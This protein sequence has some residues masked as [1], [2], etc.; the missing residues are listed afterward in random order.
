MTDAMVMRDAGGT[1]YALDLRCTHAGCNVAWKA[2]EGEF[3]CPCH[4]GAFDKEGNVLKGPPVRPLERLPVRIEG[5]IV[6]VSN[7]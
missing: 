7:G 1:V 5:G 4:G 2:A 6:K 3:Y